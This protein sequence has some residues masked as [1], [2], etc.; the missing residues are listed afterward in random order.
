MADQLLDRA[1]HGP[2]DPNRF[3]GGGIGMDC[4]LPKQE[5][6]VRATKDPNRF[7]G[8]GM[9]LDVMIMKGKTSFGLHKPVESTVHVRDLKNAAAVCQELKRTLREQ[10]VQ[11]K[12]LHHLKQY[13]AYLANRLH[14]DVRNV[15]F[16]TEVIGKAVDFT[17]RGGDQAQ[18]LC[19]DTQMLAQ[20]VTT[21]L[22]EAWTLA[23]KLA[24][25]GNSPSFDAEAAAFRHKLMNSQQ[26]LATLATSL[27]ELT[28]VIRVQ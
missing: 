13:A 14:Q 19:M 1:H 23:R 3:I 20:K 9:G 15:T 2:K 6:N 5:P 11:A 22:M 16:L 8:M 17:V 21:E 7:H 12:E 10:E 28:R 18:H 27:N 26:M 4:Q 25:N 24:S